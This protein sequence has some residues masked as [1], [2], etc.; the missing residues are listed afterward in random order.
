MPGG[1][2]ILRCSLSAW[3]MRDV[4]KDVAKLYIAESESDVFYSYKSTGGSL[5]INFMI[6]TAYQWKC[7]CGS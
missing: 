5:V 1:T 7:E 4:K 2:A 3:L 6:K